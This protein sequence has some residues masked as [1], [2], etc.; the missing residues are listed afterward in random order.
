[1]ILLLFFFFQLER[2][3]F[4][5]AL[6]RFSLLQATVGI[7]ELKWKNIETIKTLI[8]IAHTDGNYLQESWHEVGQ[9]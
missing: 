9:S 1:M 2:D 8:T 5:Q 3:T 7:R 4:I 6:S